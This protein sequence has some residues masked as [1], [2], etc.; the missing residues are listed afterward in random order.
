MV[1]SVYTVIKIVQTTPSQRQKAPKM[2]KIGYLKKII[3]IHIWLSLGILSMGYLGVGDIKALTGVVSDEE[4]T[5]GGCKVC[6]MD[7]KSEISEGQKWWKK[8]VST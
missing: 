7:P 2:E 8:W 1:E 3:D 5:I 4:P 6:I